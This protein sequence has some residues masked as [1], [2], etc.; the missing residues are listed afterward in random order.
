[1][2]EIRYTAESFKGGKKIKKVRKG[3]ITLVVVFILFLIIDIVLFVDYKIKGN[4]AF[5]YKVV[6]QVNSVV[7]SG[8]DLFFSVWEPEL[9]QDSSGLTSVL[10]V[11]IDSREVEIQNGEFVNTNPHDQHGLRNADTIMQVIYDNDNGNIFMIS[12]PRD[13]GIDI[14][15]DCLDFHGSLHWVY[16]KGQVSACL[17]GGIQTLKDT[18]EGVTGIQV[19]YY[20]FITLEAFKDVIKVVGEESEDGNKGIWIDNPEEFYEIYPTRDKGWENLYFPAGYQFLDSE[21][22]LKYARSRQYTSDFARAARQQLVISA[23]KDRVLSS[24]TLLN[25]QKLL[26]TMSAFK[27]N[28]IF[29]EPTIE[30][31]RASL[32]IARDIDDNEIVHIVL[33]DN[34]G[35]QEAYLNKRPHDKPGGPYY[36]VPTH[37]KECYGNDFCRVHE[38][39]E[40]ILQYPDIYRERANIFV[41]ARDYDYSQEPNLNNNSYL[42]LKN[43]ELPLSIKESSSLANHDEDDVIIFDFSGNSKSETLNKLSSILGVEVTNG[44]EY[45]SVR[46]NNEDIAIV[47]KGN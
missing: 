12:I 43:S 4:Q 34:F 15:K 5:G 11:G 32:N 41:Y 1:M 9:K 37:W 28:M 21:R 30:E 18:V 25:P 35:G 3:R 16:D 22:A 24:D 40:K 26:S 33:D 42:K 7:N 38:F 31:I 23:V 10:I 17:G 46:I 8:K 44:E 14:E 13:M 36:M 39:I 47:V 6:D 45:P 19:H 29:S 2:K 20:A 27:N